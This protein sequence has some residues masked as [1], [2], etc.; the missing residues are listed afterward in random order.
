MKMFEIS[1][2]LLRQLPCCNLGYICY[3][4]EKKQT[5]KTK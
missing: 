2:K 4:H 3:R 1:K 5:T